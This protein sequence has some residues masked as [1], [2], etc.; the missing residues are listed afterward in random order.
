MNRLGEWLGRKVRDPLM[1]ELRQ[2]TTPTGLAAACA[3]GAA[4]GVVPFLGTTTV[5]GLL[6]GRLLRLNHVA[7]QTANHLLY[8]MQLLLLIPFIRLGETVTGSPAMPID[9]RTLVTDFLASP[10]AFL[11]KFGLAGAHGALGW[12]LVTPVSAWALYLV[13]RGLFGKL[14]PS[15][16]QP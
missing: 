14:T 12:L 16:S 1:T 8:P 15:A 10:A 11:A 3:V 6:A 2:G 5:L 7:L 4:I 13:L 9:P